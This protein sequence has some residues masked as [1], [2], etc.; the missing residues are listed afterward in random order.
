MFGPFDPKSE[1]VS[2]L[3]PL[4]RVA[5]AYLTIPLVI[6]LAGWFEWCGALP[7]VA[8][9]VYALRPLVA[10]WPI[11]G[12]RLPVTPLQLVVAALVGCGWSVF[13]GTDHLMFANADWHIRDAVLHDLVTSPWPVGYGLLDGKETLLRAPV[14]FY[15]PAALVGKIAGLT[16]AHLALAV[17]TAIGATLFL[18][19]VL[20]LT[21][22]RVSIAI[23]V[24]AVVVLFSGL[25]I[26]GNLLNDGPRFRSDW[27]ITTHL[28]WWAGTYQY[29]SG[30]R[31]MPWAAGL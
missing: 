11:A 4:D 8:G 17:W 29:C 6:F 26:V 1:P 10:K 14:A 28:E 25:D 9:A 15:L 12:A 18:L 2:S 19:Q 24:A 23:L 27:N 7:L 21:P 5:I 31:I 30:C 3:D 13:G 16:M 20:S 22:S